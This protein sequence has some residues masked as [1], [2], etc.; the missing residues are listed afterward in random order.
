MGSETKRWTAEDREYL[1]GEMRSWQ[2]SHCQGQMDF[3][4]LLSKT[5][6]GNPA[7]RSRHSGRG[8]SNWDR[9]EQLSAQAPDECKPRL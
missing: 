5:Q 4:T 7:D 6:V 2:K 9:N 1:E 3:S 8:K